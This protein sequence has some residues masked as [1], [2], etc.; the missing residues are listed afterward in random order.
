MKTAESHSHAV[1]SGEDLLKQLNW[2]YATKKFDP[3]RKIDDA[4][5][6]VLENALRLSASSYGLQPWKF[7]VVT[8][9][10]VKKELSV[11]AYSQPQPADCSH[12]VVICRKAVLDEA[13]L[14]HYVQF[15]AEQRSLAEDKKAAFKGMMAGFINGTPAADK[16]VWAAK[17][18]YIALGFLLSAAALQGV[19]A[20]P[21]EGFDKAAFDR[22]L[23]LPEK[24]CHSVVLCPLGYRSSEDHYADLP[25]VRFPASETIIRI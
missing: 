14:D 12:L 8:D 2:R 15:T 9:P 13:Y 16:D 3:A 25:K 4:T 17:Q 20:C 21:M 10:A 22:I 23:H 1:L 24:G 11:A 19:D 18:C 5:C 7:V 6:A